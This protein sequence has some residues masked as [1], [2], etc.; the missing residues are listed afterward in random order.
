MRGVWR[1]RVTP[2][3]APNAA[4][5]AEAGDPTPGGGG[6]GPGGK[7]GDRPRGVSPGPDGSALE[8]ERDPARTR[9]ATAAQDAA[10]RVD[11]DQLDRAAARPRPERLY[12]VPTLGE[13][14]PG[15]LGDA[16]LGPHDCRHP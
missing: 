3:V 2:R 9:V 5:R 8:A 15:G 6:R 14:A 11:F 10:S 12:D 1:G 4:F 13:L 16:L 7:P